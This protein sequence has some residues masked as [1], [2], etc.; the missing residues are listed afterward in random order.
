MKPSRAVDIH[1]FKPNKKRTEKETDVTKHQE[2]KRKRLDIVPEKPKLSSSNVYAA[3][4]KCHPTAVMFSVLPGFPYEIPIKNLPDN[5]DHSLPS[6]L[7]Q[8]FDPAH[9]SLSNVEI[10]EM[11]YD[12][13]SNQLSMSQEQ[14]SFLERS[15]K[16]Q[17]SSVLWHEHRRGRI[18]SSNFSD[19]F[20]HMKSPNSLRGKYPRSIVSKIMQYETMNT[21]AVPAL[22][23]GSEKEVEARTTYTHGVKK[24]HVNSVVS[25]AGLNVN[26]KYP[27]LGA[28][29]DGY[30]SCDCCGKGLIEIKCTY[31]YRKELPV[32]DNALADKNYFLVKDP[33][34]KTVKLSREHKYFYQVQGQLAICDMSYCDFVCWTEKDIFIERISKD[35]TFISRVFPTLTNFFCKYLL[36]ELVT[37]Q[38]TDSP[39]SLTSHHNKE[40][41]VESLICFCRQPESGRMVACDNPTCKVVWFHFSCVKLKRVPR[42]TWYCSDCKPQGL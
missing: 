18:T 2:E 8:L 41:Q 17:A 23:W 38:L 40:N 3:L 21:S 1:F 28:S 33:I 37:H 27:H 6:T 42:G 12:I 25:L 10:E 24:D 30:V 35:E 36:P 16:Q 19:V 26:P 29:P 15:T 7:Y 5:P 32:S 39:C 20:H 34:S 9:A 31:K 14:S 4:Y 22:K 11:C 13:F